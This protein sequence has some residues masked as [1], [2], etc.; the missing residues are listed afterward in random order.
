MVAVARSRDLVL[1]CDE[2][3]DKI[4]YDDAVHVPAARLAPDDPPAVRHDP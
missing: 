4:L 3:Y 2:I 1:F